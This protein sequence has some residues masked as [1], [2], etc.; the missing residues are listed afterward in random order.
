MGGLE[1]SEEGSGLQLEEGGPEASEGL[2]EPP[3]TKKKR[4][5][6]TDRNHEEPHKVERVRTFVEK[7]KVI[8]LTLPPYSPELNDIERTFSWTKRALS[9]R[10]NIG[11]L[12]D[13]VKG[14]FK[15]LEGCTLAT[16][17]CRACDK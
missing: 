8:L 13:D 9:R 3:R 11:N 4:I 17:V 15:G 7:I 5:F 2:P 16:G 1:S 12:E 10:A 6:K 14:V